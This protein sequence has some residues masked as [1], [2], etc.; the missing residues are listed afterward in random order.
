MDERWHYLIFP[1]G[2]GGSVGFEQQTPRTSSYSSTPIVVVNIGIGGSD[3]GLVMTY[4]AL[5]SI[6]DAD[7][8]ILKQ[9]K[10][11]YEKLQ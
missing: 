2:P 6:A 5:A 7:V 8:P 10:A 4:E 9:A 1:W 3:P 11:E